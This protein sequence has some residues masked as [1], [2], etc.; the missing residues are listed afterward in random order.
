ML[1]FPFNFFTRNYLPCDGQCWFVVAFYFPVAEIDGNTYWRHP[2]NSLFHPK[3]LEEFIIMD[4]NRVQEKKKV[5][6]AGARSNKVRVPLDWIPWFG[7]SPPSLLSW[8]AVSNHSA[9]QSQISALLHL[10]P[11]RALL[12][13]LLVWKSH[14]RDLDSTFRNAFLLKSLNYLLLLK[15]RSSCATLQLS[16]CFCW[17]VEAFLFNQNS[18]IS[19]RHFLHS[20]KLHVVESYELK[21]PH[22]HLKNCQVVETALLEFL[23]KVVGMSISLLS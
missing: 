23:W 11:G 15:F 18:W 12:G 3:Q 2:F 6:G 4:I 21:K 20:Q 19:T 22:T 9:L 16:N 8:A 14:R 17:S 1:L 7:P 5:A 10:A 13:K